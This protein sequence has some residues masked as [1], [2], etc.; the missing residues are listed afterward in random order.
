ML[1]EVLD[2]MTKI[3]LMNQLKRFPVYED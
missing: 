2:A 1:T 3:V